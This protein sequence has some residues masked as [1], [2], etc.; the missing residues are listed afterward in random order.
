MD[1]S[2]TVPA[3]SLPLVIQ[4]AKGA[5]SAGRTGAVQCVPV[6]PEELLAAAVPH[7]RGLSLHR[8][9]P[10]PQA[11]G[12]EQRLWGVREVSLSVSGSVS[13]SVSLR[14][15]Q[16]KSV[17]EGKTGQINYVDHF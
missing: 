7:S 17:T 3:L 8:P 2:P 14:P 15:G 12:P 11:P 13:V 6:W 10:V 16:V 9:H 1:V 4:E 5:L